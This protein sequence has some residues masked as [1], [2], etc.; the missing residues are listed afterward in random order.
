MRFEI[1]GVENIF[2]GGA[3]YVRF[4][5]LHG[6]TLHVRGEVVERKLEYVEN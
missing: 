2:I 6:E 3:F 5:A 1:G 4:L